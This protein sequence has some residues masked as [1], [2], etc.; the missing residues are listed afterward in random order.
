MDQ[1]CFCSTSKVNIN[2]MSV[3]G[4][5]GDVDNEWYQG[6]YKNKF[7]K[8]FPKFRYKIVERF[9]DMYYQEVSEEEAFKQGYHFESDPEKTLKS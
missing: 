1:A 7:I 3:T 6:I 9:G 5:E 8:N 2:Y 4:F